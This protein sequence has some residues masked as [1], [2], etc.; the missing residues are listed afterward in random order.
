MQKLQR[1]EKF[2]SVSLL[3]TTKMKNRFFVITF[4]LG[5]TAAQAQQEPQFTQFMF[6]NQVYNPGYAGTSD[7]L[8]NTTAAYRNQWLGF[9][10]NPITWFFCA[11]AP[12]KKLHGGLGLKFLDDQLGNFHFDKLGLSYAWHKRIKETGLLGIGM[13]TELGR[14][15][16]KN[17]WLAP[18]GTNGASDPAIPQVN[19]TGYSGN[20]SL[21]AYYRN[22]R[23]NV[24]FSVRQILPTVYHGSQ[25]EYRAAPHFYLTAGYN[26]YFSS[27]G[28]IV[29]SIFIKSD[30][31]V[32]TFDL[33]TTV[34][35]N[36]HIWTGIS[37]RLQDAVAFMAGYAFNIRKRTAFKIGY[38]YDAG[39][40]DL[41]SYHS[42]T[43][44]VFLN[45]SLKLKKKT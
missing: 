6:F 45:Y 29:A 7:S 24:G 17:N 3:D 33:N 38:A 30:A 42:N 22:Y 14:L 10:G 27:Q 12:V 26:F 18:D 16:V 20:F 32:T 23:W 11:D 13:E 44:E 36:R 31:A 41:R 28:R 1:G 34:Y 8:L 39:I 40:S 35:W 5:L 37:Y 25:L 19:A 9:P 21:G 2:I 15:A 4:F 43:H